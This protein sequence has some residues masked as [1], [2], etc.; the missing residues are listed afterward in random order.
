MSY[1]HN[2]IF[3]Y[4]YFMIILLSKIIFIFFSQKSNLYVDFFNLCIF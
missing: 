4:V 1:L 2:M 3:I